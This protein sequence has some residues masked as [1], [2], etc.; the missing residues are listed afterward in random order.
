VGVVKQCLYCGR[1]F[2]P[3][4]RV[5]ERQKACADPGCRKK[6]KKAAQEAWVQRNPGY[7]D[8]LYEVYVKPWRKKKMIKDEI[9]REERLQRLILL[10]PDD[11]VG[12]IKDKIT[13]TRIGTRT[14]A[15]HGYG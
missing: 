4:H 1:Y 12:M 2:V 5:K 9:P 13:L 6:R 8:H 15:A 14:F 10:I 3:D 7:F 11:K